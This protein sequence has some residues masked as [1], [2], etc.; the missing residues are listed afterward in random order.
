[1]TISELNV[2]IASTTPQ[3]M[4]GAAACYRLANNK[5]MLVIFTNSIASF[6][7][8]AEFSAENIQHL[9][10]N[11]IDAE[12]PGRTLSD[13]ALAAALRRNGVD[14]ARRTVAKYR[15]TMHIRSSQQ[16][17]RQKMAQQHV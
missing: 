2:L 4:A 6:D 1:M 12:V 10:K 7:G 11:L 3:G 8:G 14:I 16:R 15:E 5:S 13:A 9:I 17:R